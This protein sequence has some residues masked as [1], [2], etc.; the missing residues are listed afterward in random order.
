[1]QLR[2]EIFEESVAWSPTPLNLVSGLEQAPGFTAGR[3]RLVDQARR[4]L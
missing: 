4:R 3:A 1:M 2:P